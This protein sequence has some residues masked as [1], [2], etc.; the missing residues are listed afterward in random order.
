L[1]LILLQKM[2]YTLPQIANATAKRTYTVLFPLNGAD[3]PHMEALANHQGFRGECRRTP[4]SGVV[5][6]IPLTTTRPSRLAVTLLIHPTP[7]LHRQSEIN[8]LKILIHKYSHA[9]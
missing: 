7:H 8:S 3:H 5:W 9:T 6:I 1:P 2:S 4:T